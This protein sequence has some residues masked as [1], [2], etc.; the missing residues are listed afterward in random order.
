MKAP[1]MQKHTADTCKNALSKNVRSVAVALNNIKEAMS[2]AA[3]IAVP[4]TRPHISGEPFVSL[5]VT[6]P[7]TRFDIRSTAID[8][9]S[10]STVGSELE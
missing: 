3:V 4:H 10:V 6:I 2:I 1:S 5:D 8:K 9:G 7:P